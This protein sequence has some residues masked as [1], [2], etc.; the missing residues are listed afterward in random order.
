MQQHSRQ[1]LEMHNAAGSNRKNN[2]KTENSV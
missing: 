2:K 1:Q